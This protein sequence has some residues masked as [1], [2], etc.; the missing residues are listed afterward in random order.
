[1]L[2]MFSTQLTGVFKRIMEEELAIED[3]ARLLAQAAAGSGTVYLYGTKEMK[4]VV[5][6]ASEGK[7]PLRNC[8]VWEA[9]SPF[10]SIKE[11]DRFLIITRDNEDQEALKLGEYLAEYYIPFAGII[12][13]AGNE[14]E[15]GSLADLADAYIDLKLAKGLLPDEEGNRIG[16]PYAMAA[17]F[18]YHG[19]K[20]TIDEILA[21]YDN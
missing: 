4:A 17:L 9:G 19:I 1:M 18:A 7:E 15:I 11:T 2:K 20:F 12:G 6:E 16:Y 13:N 5:Y 8:K 10:T 3:I 14:H 21:D